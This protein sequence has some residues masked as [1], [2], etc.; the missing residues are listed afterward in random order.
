LQN[1]TELSQKKVEKRSESPNGIR[2]SS[3]KFSSTKLIGHNKFQP[4]PENSKFEKSQQVRNKIDGLL[5]LD[6]VITHKYEF[7]S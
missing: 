6:T 3:T 4:A 7:V 2:S 5:T 1:T